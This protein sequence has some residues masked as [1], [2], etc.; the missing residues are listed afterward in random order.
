MVAWSNSCPLEFNGLHPV[1]PFHSGVSFVICEVYD[2]GECLYS[3]SVLAV[4]AH[5]RLHINGAAMTV[6]E[7]IRFYASPGV[8]VVYFWLHAEVPK[9]FDAALDVSGSFGE[10]FHDG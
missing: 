3:H 9:C 4:L 6:L 2:T 5:P 7:Q 1:S 10:S 8:V